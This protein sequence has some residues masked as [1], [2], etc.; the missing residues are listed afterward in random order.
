VKKVIPL[1]P[2]VAAMRKHRTMAKR[3]ADKLA[4]YAENPSSLVNQVTELRGGHAKRRA[5]SLSD[6]GG[7]GKDLAL[8]ASCPPRI[9]LH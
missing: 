9:M 5:S 8:C 4:A 3:I 6:L 1:D 7:L 2:A